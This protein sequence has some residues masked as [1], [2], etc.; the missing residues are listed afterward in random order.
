MA[1]ICASKNG[2]GFHLPDDDGCGARIAS[3]AYTMP[4][5]ESYPI[6]TAYG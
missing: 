1:A 3:D 5:T 4:Q 2:G 6:E